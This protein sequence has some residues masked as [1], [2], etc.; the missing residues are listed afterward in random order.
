M[1]SGAS[2]RYAGIVT[3]THGAAF[4]QMERLFP[5]GGPGLCPEPAAAMQSL[6]SWPPT[7]YGCGWQDR[8]PFGSG[9]KDVA[10]LR[11]EGATMARAGFP[12]RLP[13]PPNAPFPPGWPFMHG[14]GC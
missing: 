3:Q 1:G 8:T 14:R 7:G 13:N 2:G 10:L 4:S 5:G 9:R 11:Q 12:G 6:R